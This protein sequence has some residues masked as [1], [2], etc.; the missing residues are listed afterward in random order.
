GFCSEVRPRPAPIKPPG[1]RPQAAAAITPPRVVPSAPPEIRPAAREEAAAE[2][3]AAV[4][5]AYLA[6]YNWAVFFGW[7][8]VLYF[9]V[10]ALLR[11]GHEGVYA[12]V[13][14]PLQL[15]QTA[16]VLEV[17]RPLD[18][19]SFSRYLFSPDF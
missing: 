13:E 5:R 7:A 10:D 6:V 9:A 12:A 11:S 4:K 3:M 16:A 2:T 17:R 15:A 8:Q 14:R 18:L 1:T 19:A